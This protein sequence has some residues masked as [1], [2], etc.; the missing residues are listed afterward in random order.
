MGARRVGFGSRITHRASSTCRSCTP[1]RRLAL[2]AV[3]CST[4]DEPNAARPSR[5]SLCARARG[6]F[7]VPLG[8]GT[9]AARADDSD[10]CRRLR[11]SAA[12]FRARFPLRSF[13]VAD[14]TRRVQLQDAG[15]ANRSEILGA[16]NDAARLVEPGSDV[17]ET[18][19][20]HRVMQ[21]RPSQRA[22]HELPS[23]KKSHVRD[24]SELSEPIFF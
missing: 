7:S 2:V 3:T 1:K 21:M 8:T 24:A 17:R 9:N 10:F 12:A 11:S 6:W 13:A 4:D 5:A 20:A 19:A 23:R 14:L 16:C 15:A 18:V 22:E